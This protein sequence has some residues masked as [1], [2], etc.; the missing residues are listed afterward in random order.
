MLLVKS[1]FTAHTNFCIRSPASLLY[2]TTTQNED[3]AY[4]DFCVLLQSTDAFLVWQRTFLFLLLLRCH[5]VVQ[6][7]NS[8]QYVHLL[9]G[10]CL[11]GLS[12]KLLSPMQFP[13]IFMSLNDPLKCRMHVTPEHPIPQVSFPPLLAMASSVMLSSIAHHFS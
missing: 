7:W 10:S 12:T 9:L 3:I 11:H 4:F 5:W 13:D 8:P 6:G 2:S 1:S